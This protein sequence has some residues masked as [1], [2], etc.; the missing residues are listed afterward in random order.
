MKKILDFKTLI[1]IIG[2]ALPII[3]FIVS[4]D[5]KEL[6][7]KNIAVT[8]LV[9]DKKISDESI[10][11]FFDNEQVFNLYSISSVLTNTG[12]VP[13]INSELL[14]SLHVSFQDSVKIL[15]Y[16]INT[17]PSNIKLDK[18]SQSN[19]TL[20]LKPD[21]LN[22]KDNIHI[23]FYVTSPNEKVLP[24]ITSRIVGGEILNLNM[25]EDIRQKSDFK[26]KAFASFEGTIYWMS[27]IYTIIY[28]FIV[29]WAIY[30]NKDMNL[31][32]SLSK[33]LTFFFMSLGLICSI[34]YLIQTK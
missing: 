8:E 7:F 29:F 34:L 12:N 4:K 5:I 18:E 1:A 9:S 26:N 17:K 22:P 2:I 13:I 32:T 11:V 3:L 30:I 23:N 21:L 15:K 6:S 27:L 31:D 28:I 19:N 14:N 20:I 25:D 16:T 33:F 24:K 10:K